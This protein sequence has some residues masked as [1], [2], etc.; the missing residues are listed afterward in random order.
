MHSFHQI[1]V[2][3]LLLLLL[4]GAALSGC[5]SSEPVKLDG[6]PTFP[7]AMSS[8]SSAAWLESDHPRLKAD[9]VISVTVTREPDL[10]LAQVRIAED[11]TIDVPYVGRVMAAGMTPDD[12]AEHIRGRL[13]GGYLNDPR[14][15]VN[16][17]EY[18]SH[19]VTVEGAVS[20]PGIFPFQKGTTLLGAVALA[21]GPVR[22]AKLRQ[23]AVFREDAQG[24]SVAVFD[25]RQVRS[26]KLV[27]LPMQPGDR[28]VVGFSAL[29]Q[30]WQDF[31]QA[32]PAIGLF[33]RITKN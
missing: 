33:T 23:V 24:I 28:I 12:I 18:A 9:D 3:P 2:R 30:G 16:V 19:I 29:A 5:A 32:A 14:V 6:T 21:Q 1:P 20:K 25:L 27:D 31:L 8:P 22:S 17:V 10:S 4:G 26:G 11:G 15:A 13:S 7:T